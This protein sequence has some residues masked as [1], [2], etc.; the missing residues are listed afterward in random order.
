[1]FCIALNNAMEP[2]APYTFS[3]ALIL[4]VTWYV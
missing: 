4:F 1:M 3:V 2:K